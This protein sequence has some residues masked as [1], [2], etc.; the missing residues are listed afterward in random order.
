MNFTSEASNSSWCPGP[1]LN[2]HSTWEQDFKSCVSTDSTTRARSSRSIKIFKRCN[3]RVNPGI[4]QCLS[5]SD[6]CSR[7]PARVRLNAENFQHR[8]LL[9][10]STARKHNGCFTPERSYSSTP[11]GRGLKHRIFSK[12]IHRKKILYTCPTL[13][14]LKNRN[15]CSATDRPCSRVNH[16][17]FSHV[18]LRIALAFS[19]SLKSWSLQLTSLPLTAFWRCRWD[20]NPRIK[21]LQ[22]SALGHLATAPSKTRLPSFTCFAILL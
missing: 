7:V 15:G 14:S 17:G 22:T 10:R 6:P 13:R 3:S 2:R 12:H 11:P 21:V 16:P 8:I 9:L 4:E 18:P 19:D 1:D 5:A 20:S